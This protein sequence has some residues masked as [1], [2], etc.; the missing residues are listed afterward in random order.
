[1]IEKR[2]LAVAFGIDISMA[3]H[4]EVHAGNAG[5]RRLMREAMTIEAIDRQLAGV[6]LMAEWDGL[7]VLV[8]QICASLRIE[9]TDA[10]GHNARQQQ[11]DGAMP[12]DMAHGRF[13]ELD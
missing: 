4:A 3:A 11:G 13:E 9:E 6:E 1:M 10:G 8:G 7:P 5:C 12:Q 2:F